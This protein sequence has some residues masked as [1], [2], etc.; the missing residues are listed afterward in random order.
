MTQLLLTLPVSSRVLGKD[1]LSRRLG[2]HGSL[3]ASSGRGVRLS[4]AVL[5][6]DACNMTQQTPNLLAEYCL[7]MR[8]WWP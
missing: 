8:G 2:W 1:W 6:H 3:A 5:H 4:F 7:R